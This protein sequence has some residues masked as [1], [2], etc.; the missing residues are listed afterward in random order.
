MPHAAPLEREKLDFAL[1][2]NALSLYGLRDEG[3]NFELFTCGTMGKLHFDC[4]LWTP[5]F[6]QN[7][8]LDMQAYVYGGNFVIKGPRELALQ[9]VRRLKEYM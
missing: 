7:E 3:M 4:G 8:Q 2:G 5:C 1:C 6:F 9:L